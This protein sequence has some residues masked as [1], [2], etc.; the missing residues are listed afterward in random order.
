MS[1]QYNNLYWNNKIDSEIIDFNVELFAE[2]DEE[3]KDRIES[4]RVTNNDISDNNVF[5]KFKYINL[6]NSDDVKI[7][8]KPL[9]IENTNLFGNLIYE[10]EHRRAILTLEN[11]DGE[12]QQI[13]L[14]NNKVNP[15]EVE[16]LQICIN[17]SENSLKLVEP[18][19]KKINYIDHVDIWERNYA[20][21]RIKELTEKF[22]WDKNPPKRVLEFGC[23]SGFISAHLHL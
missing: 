1:K 15:G 7:I 21:D 12:T 19:T 2:L 16:N 10:N 5:V 22:E 17:G 18:T 20:K 23:G 8:T 3:F 4:H 14:I 11:S 13:R 9:K 6:G